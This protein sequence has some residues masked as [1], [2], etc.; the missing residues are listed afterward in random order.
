MEVMWLKSCD[1]YSRV[2]GRYH[3][4]DSQCVLSVF[5]CSIDVWEANIHLNNEHWLFF[6]KV[7]VVVEEKGQLLP[8][9]LI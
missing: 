9:L 3:Q 5:R 6:T 2:T 7:E 4:A 8:H 1:I